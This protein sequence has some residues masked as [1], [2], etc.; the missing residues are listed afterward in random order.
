MTIDTGRNAAKQMK[1]MRERFALL[2]CQSGDC[3]RAAGRFESAMDC[4]RRA[5]MLD[6]RPQ[7]HAPRLVDADLCTLLGDRALRLGDA[8]VAAVHF[9]D[10]LAAREVSPRAYRGLAAVHEMGGRPGAARAALRRAA[11]IEASRATRRLADSTATA[12]QAGSTHRFTG[13]GAACSGPGTD[14]L[15]TAMLPAA[16]SLLTTRIGAASSWH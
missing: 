1:A 3:E 15:P 11:A 8:E 9:L 4:Y 2:L 12:R 6:I 14:E 10:A 7:S 13:M 5:A 16:Q